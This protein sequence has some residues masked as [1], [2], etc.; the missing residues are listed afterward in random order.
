MVFKPLDL[1]RF[2][3]VEGGIPDFEPRPDPVTKE[4]TGRIGEER[5]QIGESDTTPGF[6]RLRERDREAPRG[7][8]MFSS[9]FLPFPA[10]RLRRLAHPSGVA[11]QIL[12]V[13]G[14]AVLAAAVRGVAVWGTVVR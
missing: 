5:H 11:E 7:A 8:G 4:E 2:F 1:E 9:R 3:L 14:A 6:I 10:H 13:W 12:S